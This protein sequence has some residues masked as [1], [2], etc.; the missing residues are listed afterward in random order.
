MSSDPLSRELQ[1]LTL[2][3]R[4]DMVSGGAVLVRI[5]VP[6]SEVAGHGRDGCC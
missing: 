3:T 4:P 5:N 6:H 1:I 2:S